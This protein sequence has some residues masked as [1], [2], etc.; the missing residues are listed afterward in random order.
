MPLEYE[1]LIWD[2]MRLYELLKPLHNGN[3]EIS[4]VIKD[5]E[6]ASNLLSNLIGND[7]LFKNNKS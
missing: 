7:K 3:K 5:Y 4:G 6:N 2:V 1:F